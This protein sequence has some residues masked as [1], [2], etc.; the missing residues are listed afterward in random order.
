MCIF[1]LEKTLI[2][3]YWS[4][5][6][7]KHYSNIIAWYYRI[8]ET[9]YEHLNIIKTLFDGNV[10]TWQHQSWTIFCSEQEKLIKISV[11]QW[12]KLWLTDK[13]FPKNVFWNIIIFGISFIII[14]VMTT[15]ITIIT[16]IITMVIVII[17]IIIAIIIMT[18]INFI[19]TITIILVNIIIINIIITI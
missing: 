1:L 10:I 17:I 5:I 15:I 13:A 6:G 4:L 18:I 2:K 16:I 8:I 14:N 12:E 11:H 19:I 9:F 3:R 7:S